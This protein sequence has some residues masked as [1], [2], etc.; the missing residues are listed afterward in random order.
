M[1]A[2]KESARTPDWIYK[3]VD[4][5]TSSNKGTEIFKDVSNEGHSR[6]VNTQVTDVDRHVLGVAPIVSSGCRAGF[7][8]YGSFIEN[9][10][11][12]REM[13]VE[14]KSGSHF[15]KLWV[16]KEHPRR[17]GRSFPGQGW[18]DP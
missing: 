3:L 9:P 10:Q 2:V 7:T 6:R 14:H 13:Q 4:G 18:S 8:R 5:N 11:S 12:H 16:P 17:G 15:M 1:R